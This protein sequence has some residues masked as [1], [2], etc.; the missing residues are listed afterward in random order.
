MTRLMLQAGVPT[1][2]TA[3]TSL[4][5]SAATVKVMQE[6]FDKMLQEV[7]NLDQFVKLM[8][9][10]TLG[11]TFFAWLYGHSLDPASPAK[12]VFERIAEKFRRPA[13]REVGP[14]D[15]AAFTTLMSALPVFIIANP[16]PPGGAR[17][18]DVFDVLQPATREDCYVD[19]FNKWLDVW[20]VRARLLPNQF[21]RWLSGGIPG[22][23]TSSKDLTEFRVKA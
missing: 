23:K 14:R 12:D 4:P 1:S 13:L 20:P 15:N 11:P 2:P 21:A 6:D 18:V 19:I 8:S 5:T 3:Q 17:V 16:T 7:D 22:A 9:N 10:R